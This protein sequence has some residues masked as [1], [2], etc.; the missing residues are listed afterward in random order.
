MQRKLSCGIETE[1]H[2]VVVAK[3][4]HDVVAA[5]TRFLVSEIRRLKLFL[6]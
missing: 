6:G 3:K 1:T 2:D 4:T 5:K